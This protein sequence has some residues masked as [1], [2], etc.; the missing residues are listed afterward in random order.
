MSLTVAEAQRLIIEHA[1]RQPTERVTLIAAAGLVLAEPV[2]A[3]MDSPP[4]DKSL[5][6]GYA[7]RSGDVANGHADLAVVGE[8]MAGAVAHDAVANGTALRIMTGA[9]MPEGADSVVMLERTARSAASRITV[10]DESFRT[11]QNVMPRGCE[12]RAGETVLEAGH[13]L[14]A[15]EIGLL[16][17]VGET[18]P[19]VYRRVSLAIIST[20]DELVSPDERPGPGAIRNSN[21]ASLTALATSTG[22]VVTDLG[23]VRDDA[24]SLRL[25]IRSGLESNV[26]VLT[27]GVSM[28]D[29]DLVPGVLHELGVE[30]VFHKVEFKPGRPVWFGEHDRG[31]VFGLPGNPVSSLVCFELFV[32]TALRAR[33]SR[34][35]ATPVEIPVWLVREFRYPTARLCYHPARLHVSAN[36]LEVEPVPWRGSP[37]LCSVTKADCL[38]ICPP[39]CD[40]FPAGAIMRAIR[41]ERV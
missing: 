7:I 40:V 27:G 32:R 6:D 22:A 30:R 2:R 8:L 4:F 3:D 39:N 38:L 23:I 15:P 34:P 29:R 20:G 9:P 5:V 36:C 37:D 25:A 33:Q 1:G 19:S 13:L 24:V 41:I 35:D 26:L 18:R 31:L 21:A 17:S 16:A 10:A 11:R 28:G 12:Y 14:G